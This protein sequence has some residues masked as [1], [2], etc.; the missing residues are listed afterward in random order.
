MSIRG[1][2]WLRC[3]TTLERDSDEY[4]HRM[5]HRGCQIKA[6]RESPKRRTL[7]VPFPY[8]V[9]GGSLSTDCRRSLVRGRV[10]GLR[11]ADALTFSTGIRVPFSFPIFPWL[12]PSQPVEESKRVPCFPGPS[13]LD[14]SSVARSTRGY[15]CVDH[16][17]SAFQNR[18]RTRTRARIRPCTS[19]SMEDLRNLH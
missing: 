1:G 5:D 14:P 7:W 10:C 17:H 4:T 13:G 19:E 11:S 9:K 2:R 6:R 18:R 12:S 8:N 3:H 15:A 16:D